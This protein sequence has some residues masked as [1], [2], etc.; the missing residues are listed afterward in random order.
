ME[1]SSDKIVVPAHM[2]KMA[3]RIAEVNSAF[4]DLKLAQDNYQKSVKKLNITFESQLKKEQKHANKPKKE[5]KACGF[6]VA[7]AVSDAMCE[8]MEVEKGSLIARTDIT[9][10]LNAYIKANTLEN[11]ENRQQIL[12]D[13]KLWKILGEDAKGANITHFTIQKYINGHFIKKASVTES[14]VANA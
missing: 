3:E 10:K 9:K 4:N 13:E 11:P 1:S 8:F 6:A 7:V 5:R 12:P 14:V 2:K